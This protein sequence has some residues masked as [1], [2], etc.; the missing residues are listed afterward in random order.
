MPVLVH[1][2]V[3]LSP[4]GKGKLSK[5]TQAFLDSG[6]KVLVRADEF[7][8]AGYLREALLNFLINVGW[9]FGDDVEKFSMEEAIARFDLADISPSPVK[10]PYSKLDW[11]NGQYIQ[12]MSP[13][14]LAGAITPHLE[15]AGFEVETSNLLPLMPALSVRLKRLTEAVD[16]L[17]FLYD[18]ELPTYVVDDL[19]HRKMGQAAARQAFQE[20][21]ELV[22]SLDDPLPVEA[23][24]AGMREIGERNTDNNK[25]GPFLGTARFA[26]T[27][28][29]VSPPLF[30][31][32]AALGKEHCLRRLDNIIAVLSQA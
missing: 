28:Q 14:E 32:M 2:P 9:H 8:V 16:Q 15:D 31:S 23:L 20:T 30:E 1:F 18:D 4:S 7:R 29:Q 3:I 10:L 24:D 19:T 21:R 25:A 12:E 13:M 5:R 22:A 11:L 27:G 17:R 6:E 26:I